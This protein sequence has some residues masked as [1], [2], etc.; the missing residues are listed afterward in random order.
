[1][2]DSI[3]AR[4]A[5]LGIKLPEPAAPVAAYVPA[6]EIGGLLYISG[7]LP[8][9]EDGSLITGRLG[10]DYDLAHGREAARAL[11][12]DAARADEE[13]ARLARP[14]RADRQARRVRR[15][16]PRISPT[17]RRSPTAPRS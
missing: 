12:G 17:S 11:R 14:G 16:G 9:R 3:D 6:V 7:Q 10:E 1:M 2:T 15:L 13:G 5:E 8:F 4:L